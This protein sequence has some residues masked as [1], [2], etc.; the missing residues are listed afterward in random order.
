MTASRPRSLADARDGI[1]VVIDDLHEL[2][3]PEGLAQL[4]T[5]LP[6]QVHAIL[7]TRHD[8]RLRLQQLRQAL[9]RHE[10]AHAALLCGYCRPAARGSAAVTGSW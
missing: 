3:S 8:L 2:H 10:T 1:T 4:L 5:N 7:A 9:P 6:P